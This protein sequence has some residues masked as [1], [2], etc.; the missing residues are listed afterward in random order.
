MR[1]TRQIFVVVTHFVSYVADEVNIYL[2]K[3]HVMKHELREVFNLHN[4]EIYV[5]KP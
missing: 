1:M 3:I 5:M 2:V 4:I